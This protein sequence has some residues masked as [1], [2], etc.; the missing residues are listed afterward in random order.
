MTKWILCFR[1]KNINLGEW[2]IWSGSTKF[3]LSNEG[4]NVSAI[5]RYPQARFNQF[6]YDNDV[7]LVEVA[8]ALTF[9]PNVGAVCLPE[10]EIQPRQICVTAGWT[11]GPGTGKFSGGVNSGVCCTK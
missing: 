8:G 1:N 3:E 5:L 6:L 9:T 10:H 4:H 7:A 11:V 2:R